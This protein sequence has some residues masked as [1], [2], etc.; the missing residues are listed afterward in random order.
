LT[1]RVRPILDSLYPVWRD[2]N[3]ENKNFE[4]QAERDA[5]QLLRA[6]IASHEEIRAML[7]GLDATPQLSASQLHE[8]VWRAASAQWSTSHFQEAVLA[9]AKAVN[10][11]LQNK[12]DRRYLSDVKLVREA[13]ADS[14]PAP[15]RPRL[16][17]NR[18]VDDQRGSRCDKG[19]C[20]SA[21]AASKPFVT[22][23]ATCSS[24]T[25]SRIRFSCR[26]R[27]R[28]SPLR[29]PATW[30]VQRQTPS[31]R[32][33]CST[34]RGDALIPALPRWLSRQPTHGLG[35]AAVPI[36]RKRSLG[37]TAAQIRRPFCPARSLLRR[38]LVGA[39]ES[40]GDQELV[41]EDAD[42]HARL[43]RNSITRTVDLDLWQPSLC[44]RN[45]RCLATR[46]E[47]PASGE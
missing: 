30:G 34:R 5:C 15:G 31:Y 41:R 9:A 8:L 18:V 37:D 2:E 20:P 29:L 27:D 16:R 46:E 13:F 21:S 17:F 19:R 39:H 32:P 22:R 4:F 3:R 6:R 40:F 28:A 1:E 42:A 7:A 36:A 45:T 24:P 23:L 11:M 25:G 33:L 35:S 38:G 47:R 44:M 43:P 12:L 14:D 10:S 26:R